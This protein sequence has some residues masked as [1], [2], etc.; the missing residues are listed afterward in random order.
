M[1]ENISLCDSCNCMTKSIR[2]GHSEIF[3]CWNSGYFKPRNRIVKKGT[4]GKLFGGGE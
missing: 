3:K 1:K 4:M 2:S